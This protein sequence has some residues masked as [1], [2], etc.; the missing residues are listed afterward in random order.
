MNKPSDLKLATVPAWINGKPVVPQG[1]MGDV[2][3][4]ATGRIT[5]QVPFCDATAVGAAVKAAAAA[6][7]EWRDA[8]ILRR[9]RHAEVPA[10]PAGAPEG[11]READHR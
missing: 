2:Y 7:P 11:H 10:A 4:P 9:A 3:N 5:K 1:R 8:S 6:L